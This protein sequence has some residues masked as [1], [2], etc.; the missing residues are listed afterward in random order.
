MACDA[1]L[2]IEASH[3]ITEG[4]KLPFLYQIHRRHKGTNEQISPAV[5]HKTQQ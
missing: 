1:L 5:L 2:K 3:G 4:L